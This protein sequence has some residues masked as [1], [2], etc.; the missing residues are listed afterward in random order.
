MSVRPNLDGPE[1][2]VRYLGD[3]LAEP[4]REAFEEHFLA[5]PKV[6]EE[7]ELDAKLKAGLICIR[8]A[9]EL[10]RLNPG[11]RRFWAS[12]PLAIAA[13]IL[14]MAAI[15]FVAFRY[16]APQTVLATS[17]AAL[18]RPLGSQPVVGATFKLMST[19]TGLYDAVIALPESPQALRL[20]MVLDIDPPI[21]TLAVTLSAIAA[22]ASR[23]NLMAL[24]Q[25]RADDNGIVTLYLNSA[26][27]QPGIYE[28]AVSRDAEPAAQPEATFTLSVIA[29]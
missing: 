22:D 10:E 23:T 15:S 13:S 3:K 7:M 24:R 6:V 26:A 21:P 29:P 16:A 18:R 4:E 14:F 8:D 27:V 25:L 17:T 5:R 1:I 2:A 9:G 20:Q 19:R 12:M 11:A 28:L